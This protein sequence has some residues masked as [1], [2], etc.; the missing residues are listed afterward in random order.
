MNDP[1]AQDRSISPTSSSEGTERA[2]IGGMESAGGTPAGIDEAGV[3][4]WFVKH[5]P[6]VQLPLGYRQIT[7]GHSNL[8]FEVTDDAGRRFVL[9]RPPTGPL[10]PTAH[11]MG[12]EH[13]IISAVGPAGIPAPDAIG[14]CDDRAVTG[15]PFYVMSF[16]DGRVLRDEGEAEAFFERPARRAIGEHLVEVLAALHA[17]DPDELGL[18][19]LSRKEGY[20]ARQLK[21]WYG[22][23]QAVRDTQG[24]PDVAEIDEVHAALVEDIPPQGPASIVHGDYRLDN[25][26]IGPDARVAAVLDW[27]LCTL[28]DPLADVGQLVVY[29][30]EPGEVS[31]IHQS[32]TSAPGFLSRAELA[33][34][35]AEASGRDID[36]LDYYIAFAYWKLACILE[37]VYTRYAAGALG[38]DDAEYLSYP[39]TIRQLGQ[40]A[41]TVVQRLG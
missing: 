10:L 39:E 17:I 37:G 18:G 27:E 41:A 25:T 11:D 6:G 13:R 9:R 15:A 35:Y 40:R 21:R 34:G 29:W 28:G 32:G 7:G 3:G 33:A 1:A 24:G 26:V 16:V 38:D 12:R 23:Y 2:E 36:Q 30:T 4:L 8:T 20:I 19:D 14:Y 5:V 22:Q 31:P